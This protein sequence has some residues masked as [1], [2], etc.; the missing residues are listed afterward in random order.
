MAT[1]VATNEVAEFLQRQGYQTTKVEPLEETTAGFGSSLLLADRLNNGNHNIIFLI[2]YCSIYYVRDE[3]RIQDKGVAVAQPYFLLLDFFCERLISDL[4]RGIILSSRTDL[5]LRELTTKH[6]LRD[7]A[8]AC[9][10]SVAYGS[11]LWRIISF[12]GERIL[13]MVKIRKS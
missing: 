11:A 7:P 5:T 8:S 6:L 1:N 10:Y 13:A 12:S 2:A 4:C 9:F 3:K